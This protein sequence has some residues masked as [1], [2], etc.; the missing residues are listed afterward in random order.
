MSIVLTDTV[1]I[2]VAIALTIVPL[3]KV[4]LDFIKR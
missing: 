1:I 2:A 3:A 4:I